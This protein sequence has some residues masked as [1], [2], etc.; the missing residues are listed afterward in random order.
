MPRLGDMRQWQRETDAY[1]DWLTASGASATT[2]RL[3]RHYLKHLAAQCRRGPWEATT[4]ELVGLLRTPGWAAETRKSARSAVRGFYS[5]AVDT[6]RIDR[7]PARALPSVRIPQGKPRP[8]P[9]HVVRAAL[10]AADGKGRTMILL[11]LLAGLRRS[12][13]A[14]AHTDDIERERTGDV[15]RVVGKGGRVRVIPLHES[16]AADLATYPAGFVFP[17]K[18]DGH[19]SPM[20]VGKRLAAMLGA[21]WSGHTLRHRFSTDAYAAQRDLFAV[22]Q[23]LGHSKPETTARYTAIPDDSL[24]AAVRGLSSWAA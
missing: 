15:L 22:Q 16:L 12:E 1:I 7:D 2:L 11:A 20:W 24:R 18:V 6:N 17:G 13:I 5:W 19:L 14:Q 10:L 9:A 8:T 3:R 21:G 4:D 23:L